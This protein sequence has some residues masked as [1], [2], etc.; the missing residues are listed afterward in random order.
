[1]HFERRI[2]QF[3]KED[4]SSKYSN[5]IKS[6]QSYNYPVTD[7]Y[8]R[9]ENIAFKAGL[10]ITVLEITDGK[11]KAKGYIPVLNFKENNLWNWKSGP[12]QLFNKESPLKLRECY[13]QLAKEIV[14]RFSELLSDQL[15]TLIK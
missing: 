1:M 4:S 5:I 10:D 2:M 12:H 3:V 13:A 7:Y 11:G 14:Y 8:S 6:I 9:F 15:S